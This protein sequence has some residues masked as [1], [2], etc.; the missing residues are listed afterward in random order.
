MA[1]E[2]TVFTVQPGEEVIKLIGKCLVGKIP[3]VKFDCRRSITAAF[4]FISVAVAPVAISTIFLPCSWLFCI[5]GFR[6]GIAILF[7]FRGHWLSHSNFLMFNNS[8]SIN[9]TSK[10]FQ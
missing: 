9:D 4:V 3:N 5:S 8:R 10:I 7:R 1:L 2:H 6:F